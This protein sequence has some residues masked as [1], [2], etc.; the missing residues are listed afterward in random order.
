MELREHTH[1]D[2]TKIMEIEEKLLAA[3]FYLTNRRDASQLQTMEYIKKKSADQE[4][5]TIVYRIA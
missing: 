2:V 3:G 1:T 4:A 5:I